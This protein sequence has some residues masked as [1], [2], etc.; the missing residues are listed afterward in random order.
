MDSNKKNE[1]KPTLAIN[2]VTVKSGVRAGGTNSRALTT[3]F[4]CLTA[5]CDYQ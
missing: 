5:W 3:A 2:R 4:S 1:T